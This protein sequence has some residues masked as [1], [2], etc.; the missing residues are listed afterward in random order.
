MFSALIHKLDKL[1]D[2]LIDLDVTLIILGSAAILMV[3][4]VSFMAFIN[5]QPMSVQQLSVDISTMKTPEQQALFKQC[6]RG[7]EPFGTPYR[8]RDAELCYSKI[9]TPTAS[10]KLFLQQHALL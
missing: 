8:V 1:I 4:I 7:T 5:G 9:K 10:A 2:K 3:A 6:L